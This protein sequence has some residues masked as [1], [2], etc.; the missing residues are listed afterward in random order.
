M[1]RKLLS[2]L[3]GIAPASVLPGFAPGPGGPRGPARQPAPGASAVS[4]VTSLKVLN[5]T[6][7]PEVSS[8]SARRVADLHGKTI[9]E[10]W[11]GVFRGSEIFPIYRELLKA[12]FP[13][14]K[15]IPYTEFPVAYPNIDTIGN[16]VKK[17]GCDAV[18]VGV[19]G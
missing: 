10:V 13:D 3:T 4:P 15:F 17:N 14:A 5:P 6:G 19:G 18:I 7:E 12:R 1:K 2:L 16:L 8:I 11:Q 9:C